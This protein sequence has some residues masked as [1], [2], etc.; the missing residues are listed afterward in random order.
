VPAYLDY[1]A[2]TPLCPASLEVMLPWLAER[3]GNPSGSHALARAA[4]QAVD[5][6]RET[7][8]ECTGAV[9][10][11]VVFTSGGTESTNL[12]IWGR[13]LSAPGTVVV[14]AIEH[15]A[16]L[17]AA[18][19]LER[20][21]LAELRVV[22][23]TADGLIDLKALA[24]ALDEHVTL[25]SVQLVNNEVG[26]LQPLDDVSRMV[27]RRAPNSVLHTDAVQAAPWYDL[28][29]VGAGAD[30]VSLSGHKFGGPQ[31]SG[32]LVMR[33]P[34]PLAP[35]F[36]GGPQERERRAGT[37]NVAGIVGL[38][39][40]LKATTDQREES[41]RRASALRD[42]LLAGLLQ[43]VP[44]AYETAAGQAK[45]PGH[46]HLLID[47]VE[48]EALLVLL[49]REGVYASA[50]SA[51]ASGAMEPS[52]VLTAMG[53]EPAQ[54]LGA[55]RLT[56]GHGTADQDVDLALRVVPAA[57]ARLRG[58]PMGALPATVR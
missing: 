21:G 28:A 45:A 47:R 44:E 39:A 51:C 16:V 46:C 27:R 30:M 31:G 48:S 36:H 32:A 12:A 26:T 9:P 34:V 53:Y 4:C 17:H 40:A 1:A 14:S 13:A 8:A 15:H 56:L 23:V 2:T 11:G 18:Q 22:P 10:G 55:L 52:H 6:A 42:R 7:V 33:R 24:S 54:A 20:L 38:A 35:L 50:G 58:V 57:V 41:A 29:A 25:V 37:H 49:D 3:F 19:A 5:E 43:S